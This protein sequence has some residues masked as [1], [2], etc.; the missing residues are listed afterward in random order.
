MRPSGS[1]AA[2]AR[3]ARAELT[4]DAKPD[5][6]VTNFEAALRVVRAVETGVISVN[7]GWSAPGT[8]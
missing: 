4:G 7:T 8:H 3:R 2:G 1:S 6:V 5:L